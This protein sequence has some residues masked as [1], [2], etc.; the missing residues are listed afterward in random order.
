MFI[1]YECDAVRLVGIWVWS[2]Y[3]E[4]FLRKAWFGV[5]VYQAAGNVILKQLCRI[6][7]LI[8]FIIVEF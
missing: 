1:C 2:A 6:A 3:E 8:N 4:R 7:G 5:V